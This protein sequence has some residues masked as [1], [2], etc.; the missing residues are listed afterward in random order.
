MAKAK[1]DKKDLLARI[2]QRYRVMVEA[3]QENRRNAMEDMKFAL[4][5]GEQWDQDQKKERGDRPC[6]EFNKI[7]VTGKR[8]V[9]DMRANRP[10]GKVRAVEDNDKAAADAMEGLCRNIWQVSDG[11]TVIDYAGEYQVFGGMGAWR[12]IVDYASDDVFHQ[13]VRVEAL[14]NPFCL[15]A[16]LNDSHHHD[17]KTRSRPKKPATRQ[18]AAL[19]RHDAGRHHRCRNTRPDTLS[20]LLPGYGASQPSK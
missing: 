12:I 9:N 4:V 16:P 2:R 7:R 5:P 17:S 11:D 19:G 14:R 1:R 18:I 6:Y 13:D 20:T 3:D 15:F 8:I 10:Q